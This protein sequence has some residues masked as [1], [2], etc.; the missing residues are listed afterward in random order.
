M[1]GDWYEATVSS[2]GGGGFYVD[3]PLDK[4]EALAQIRQLHANEW[5]SR[6]TRA[7]FVD[8]TVYSANLNLFCIVK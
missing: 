5:I 1:G 7:V 2:Y 6:A 3:L 4:E 8:F